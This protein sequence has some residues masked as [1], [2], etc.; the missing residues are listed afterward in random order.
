MTLGEQRVRIDFNVARGEV[1]NDIVKIKEKS[2]ELINL[3]NEYVPVD[4]E[5]ARLKATAL[6]NIETGAMYAVKAVTSKTN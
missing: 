3:I 6:T 4:G 5:A 1:K 2:A